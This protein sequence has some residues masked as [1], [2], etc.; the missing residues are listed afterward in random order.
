MS[1][2]FRISIS[3]TL[4]PR[5]P[6]WMNFG[7]ARERLPPSSGFHFFR[8]LGS[9]SSQTRLR[10]KRLTVTRLLPLESAPITAAAMDEAQRRT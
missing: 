5:N 10:G 4:A 9:H 3:K 2:F 8:S 7:E 6:P 1:H